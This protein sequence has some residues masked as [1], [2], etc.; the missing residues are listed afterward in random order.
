MDAQIIL[1]IGRILFGGYFIMMGI[2]H[3]LKKDM[4]IPYAQSRGV[5][6]PSIPIVLTGILLALG[7]FSILLGAYV[8]WGVIFL[9]MFLLIAAFKMHA[10]WNDEGEEKMQN[11]RYFMTNMAYIGA[12]L[13]T[14][15]LYSPDWQWA[16]NLV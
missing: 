4:M 7:G 2:N 6:N 13:I 14:Y 15:A 3:F 16:L 11:M 12:L 10:F 5:N 1:F 8:A 9:V